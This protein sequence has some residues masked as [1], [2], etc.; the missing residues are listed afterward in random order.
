MRSVLFVADAERSLPTRVSR[1]VDA[2]ELFCW[3][4]QDDFSNLGMRAIDSTEI[5]EPMT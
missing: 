3:L 1:D 4:P 2:N 5:T